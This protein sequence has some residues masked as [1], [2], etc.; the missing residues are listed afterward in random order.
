MNRLL[1]VRV[2][3]SN[4]DHH[5]WDNNGTWFVHCTIHLP[6]HT[7]A[8]IRHSLRTKSLKVARRRRDRI[9]KFL[10]AAEFG[11]LIDWALS[12]I[13]PASDYFDIAIANLTRKWVEKSGG[14]N[15]GYK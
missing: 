5:L 3:H 15:R 10:K 4:P 6:D 13:A 2:D 9:I 7:K 12:K 14:S 8:R 1:S 11:D